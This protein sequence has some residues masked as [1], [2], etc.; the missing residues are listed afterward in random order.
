MK[1]EVLIG[2]NGRTGLPENGVQET[3]WQEANRNFWERNPMQYDWKND[4]VPDKF[5]LD[6]YREIDNRFLGQA[7]EYLPRS[8]KPFGYLIPY[9][10]LA[11]MDCLEIGVGCGTHAALLASSSKSFTGIDLTDHAIECTRRRFECFGLEGSIKCMDAERMEFEDSSFDFIWSWGVI[12]HSSNTKN[13]LAEMWR[14]LRPGGRAVVMVYSRNYWNYY[15]VHGIG[16]GIFR[17]LFFK[18][19]SI[20]DIM[21]LQTDGALARFYARDEWCQQVMPWFKVEKI[22]VFGQK[23]DLLPIPAGKFKQ[24]VLKMIPDGFGRFFTHHLGWGNF[25]V[26]Q[27]VRN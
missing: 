18:G 23:S 4:I 2:F 8:D 16:H 5:S 11:M 3:A 22:E 7:A 6:Y 15:I 10:R 26:A 27:M 20:S 21:Q 12:H 19:Y 14:V 1:K 25:L 24:A 17:G 13:V 9:D